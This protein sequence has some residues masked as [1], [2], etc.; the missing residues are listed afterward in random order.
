MLLVEVDVNVVVVL[1][2]DVDELVDVEDDVDVDVLVDV[3]VDVVLVVVSH[4]AQVLAHCF[5]T[6][7]DVHNFAAKK[8]SHVSRGEMF[9]LPTHLCSVDVVEVL[10]DVLVYVLVDVDVEVDVLVEDEV[11]VL[12][13]LLVYVAVEVDV[14]VEV[15][16]VVPH[17]PSLSAS[18]SG[19]RG[20]ESS[21]PQRPSL[22]ISFSG[23]ISHISKHSS[24]HVQGHT[25]HIECA[26]HLPSLAPPWL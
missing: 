2:D 17:V 12:V 19:C 20:Q 23:S 3:D 4:S 18:L 9:T 7:S 25:W 13:E 15:D 24:S 5:T 8:R 11:D 26:M 6:T 1:V 21:L 22:S 10:V 16:V 14:E